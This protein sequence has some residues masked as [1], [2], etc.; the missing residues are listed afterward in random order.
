MQYAA[1]M[2]FREEWRKRV[3]EVFAHCDAIITPTC[4]F[5]APRI[6]DAGD[7]GDT[8]NQINRINFTW[9]LAGVPALS[10]PCGFVDSAACLSFRSLGKQV[11]GN[12]FCL[13]DPGF[14]NG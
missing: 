13:L 1:A 6:A 8:S 9:S 3:R 10:V 7:M 2:R 4:A 5:A 11:Q 12:S 14:S